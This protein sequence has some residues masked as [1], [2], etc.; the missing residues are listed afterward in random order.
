MKL[1]IHYLTIF[2]T[3]SS[4]AMIFSCSIFIFWSS[5]FSVAVWCNHWRKAARFQFCPWH[6][7]LLALAR[8]HGLCLLLCL[9]HSATQ[10]GGLK[11]WWCPT[12]IYHT[13][14]FHFFL[15]QKIPKKHTSFP[16]YY[17][18]IY[19]YFYEFFISLNLWFCRHMVLLVLALLNNGYYYYC[20]WG[21]ALPRHRTM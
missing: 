5:L 2:P 19:T 18:M 16:Q 7:D 6:S 14:M 8:R 21:M 17:K 9:V 1:F 4:Y 20:L 10:R 13:F 11:I 15:F 12:S 3:T